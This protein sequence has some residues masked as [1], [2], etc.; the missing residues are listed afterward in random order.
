MLSRNDIALTAAAAA[1]NDDDDCRVYLPELGSNL[2]YLLFD[3]YV[4]DL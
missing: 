2:K 3:P 4:F 1:A